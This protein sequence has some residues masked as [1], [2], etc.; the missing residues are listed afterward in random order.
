M[1]VYKY[2]ALSKEASYIIRPLRIDIPNRAGKSCDEKP[3][4]EEGSIIGDDA[5][6]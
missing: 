6:S 5:M 1:S 3:D 2:S 4:E